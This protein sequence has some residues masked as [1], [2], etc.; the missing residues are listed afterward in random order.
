MQFD[1]QSMLWCKVTSVSICMTSVHRHGPK[2]GG[3]GP[4]VTQWGLGQG[5]PS[6]QVA[7]W[8]IQPFGH[9]KH[10]PKIGGCAPFLG[11][12]SWVPLPIQHNVAWIENYLHTKWHASWYGGRPRPKRLYSRLYS[13]NCLAIIHQHHRQDRQNGPIA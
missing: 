5:L 1:N 3:L 2:I 11:R 7:S 12:G 10:G 9:K 8:S 6:Y 13:S 4:H